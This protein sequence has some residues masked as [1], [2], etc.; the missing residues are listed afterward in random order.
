MAKNTLKN[1]RR[2]W[3]RNRIQYFDPMLSAWLKRDTQTGVI[4]DRKKGE[5]WKGIRQE[6]S[7]ATILVFPQTREADRGN[8]LPAI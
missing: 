6:T 1:E 4:L 2:G 8:L 3:I 5:P 7:S